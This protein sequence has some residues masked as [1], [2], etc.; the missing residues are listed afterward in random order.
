MKKNALKFAAVGLVAGLGLMFAGAAP[1]SAD[2]GPQTSASSAKGDG[3]VAGNSVDANVLVPIDVEC[4]GTGVGGVGVGIGASK[5][6][7]GYPEGSQTAASSA[8]GDGFIAG[9][10]AAVNLAVPIDVLCNVTGVGGVGL[11]IGASKCG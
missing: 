4:N 7:P 10:S 6:A 5:C 1:A 8:K 9:N 2:S 3:V 11:G